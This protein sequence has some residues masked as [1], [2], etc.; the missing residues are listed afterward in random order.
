M[1]QGSKGNL[2]GTPRCERPGVAARIPFASSSAIEVLL[3]ASVVLLGNRLIDT[4]QELVRNTL[5][6]KAPACRAL[7]FITTLP[8]KVSTDP[9]H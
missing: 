5:I 6:A 2:R 7:Q 9:P 4:L 8:P 3:E 1:E